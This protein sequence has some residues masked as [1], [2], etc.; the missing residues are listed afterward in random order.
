MIFRLVLAKLDK[1]II[2]LIV[3]KGKW[4]EV[5][6]KSG[7]RCLSPSQKK[8][9]EESKAGGKIRIPTSRFWSLLLR[10]IYFGESNNFTDND[11]SKQPK[12]ILHYEKI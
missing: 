6:E 12:N 5:K 1:Y 8:E 10:R 4:K 9:E 11:F 3:L 2:G 7:R